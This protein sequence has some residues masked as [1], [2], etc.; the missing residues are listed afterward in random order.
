MIVPMKKVSLV[1]LGN[2]KSETLQTLRQLGILHIEI[3]EGSG[4]KLNELKEQVSM[5]EG[6]NK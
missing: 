4:E 2:K 3:T 1:I 6:E 5:F